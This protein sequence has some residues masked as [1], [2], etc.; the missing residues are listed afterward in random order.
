MAAAGR[1]ADKALHRLDLSLR[2]DQ[3]ATQHDGHQDGRHAEEVQGV[4]AE[5]E[6]DAAGARGPAVMV[7]PGHGVRR[8]RG[9]GAELRGQ[10]RDRV[11]VGDAGGQRHEDVHVRR[12]ARHRLPGLRVELRAEDE[13]HGRRQ[14]QHHQRGDVDVQHAAV[15]GAELQVQGRQHD[16]DDEDE[17]R[18]QRAASEVE[19]QPRRMSLQVGNLAVVLRGCDLD[20]GVGEL[21]THVREQRA[22]PHD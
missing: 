12:A 13:L 8:A 11:G 19:P 10:D 15:H 14:E 2:L 21:A 22:S 9:R 4:A 7:V 6:V 18:G 16:G 20:A 17:G 1:Q 5:A 3:L